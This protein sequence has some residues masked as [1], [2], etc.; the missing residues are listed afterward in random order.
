MTYITYAP[1][2]RQ[3]AKLERDCPPGAPFNGVDP[4]AGITFGFAL[5]SRY[6]LPAGEP[7]VRY[8][9]VSGTVKEDSSIL[10]RKV[11]K[12]EY[13]AAEAAEMTARESLKPDPLDL[14]PMEV[15]AAQAQ[16]A[17]YNAGLLEL[18]EENIANHPYPPIRI[19]FRSATK[20]RRDNPYVLGMAAELGISDEQFLD[21]FTE[22]GKVVT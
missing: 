22:A 6:P 14:V 19:W 11:S 7:D 21:L 1:I 4:I 8:G 12:A 2:D 16:V 13:D 20:W 5:E 18:V 15:T 10:L 17:L 3:F 9:T